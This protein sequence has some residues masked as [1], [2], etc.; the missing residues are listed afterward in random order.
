M[1][2]F[3]SRGLSPQ[4]GRPQGPPPGTELS[5]KWPHTG[6]PGSRSCDLR[7]LSPPCPVAPT[8]AGLPGP[9]AAYLVLGGLPVLGDLCSGSRRPL[10]SQGRAGPWQPPSS[11]DRSG[12]TWQ[13]C[14]A[15]GPCQAAGQ[16]L[17]RRTQAWPL[18]REDHAGLMRPCRGE[19]LVTALTPEVAPQARLP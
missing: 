8:K 3:V 10:L 11:W 12:L 5:G 14:Q 9:S 1:V 17:C 7:D 18:P 13:P 19:R 2:P 15:P 4:A 6:R 16:R